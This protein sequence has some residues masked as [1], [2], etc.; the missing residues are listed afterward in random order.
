[1]LVEPEVRLKSR[2][3][4]RAIAPCIGR[5]PKQF[6]STAI[7]TRLCRKMASGTR[8]KLCGTG[9]YEVT[10]FSLPSTLR[11]SKRVASVGVQI[12]DLDLF[13]RAVPALAIRVA[14][15]D[16]HP[17]HHAALD[18][19]FEEVRRGELLDDPPVETEFRPPGPCSCSRGTRAGRRAP[20]PSRRSQRGRHDGRAQVIPGGAGAVDV[21]APRRDRLRLALSRDRLAEQ[22]R[23]LEVGERLDVVEVVR[24][25]RGAW[26]TWP[27]PRAGGDRGRCSSRRRPRRRSRSRRRSTRP[28]PSSRPP[29]S[30]RTSTRSRRRPCT[31]RRAAGASGTRGDARARALEVLEQ[32]V[33]HASPPEIGRPRRWSADG[34]LVG[35]SAR[36]AGFR[37]GS[38]GVTSRHAPSVMW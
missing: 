16:L 30:G 37:A 33:G 31:S 14:G 20:G 21:L 6:G 27:S 32:R 15:P 23:D 2:R 4:T 7:G 12:V 11:T 29:A 28:G 36:F 9:A 17:L 10:A 3:A 5:P 19:P 35:D 22:V 25:L 8:P 18:L 1:M 38:A 24:D 13:R 34:A 26:R